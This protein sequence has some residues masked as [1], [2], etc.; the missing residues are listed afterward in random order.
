MCVRERDKKLGAIKICQHQTLAK[1]YNKTMWTW[2]AGSTKFI[3]FFQMGYSRPLFLYFHLYNSVDSKMFNINFCRW[4]DSDR[5]PLE[6]EATTLPTEPQPL[7]TKFILYVH[8]G[9][10]GCGRAVASETSGQSYKH[11]TLVNYDT[12]VVI[13]GIF[14]S[15]MTLVS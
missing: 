2:H 13:W 6:L 5:R 15:G 14:Q 7:T 9:S 4:V 11:F 8:I 3:L 12:R 1:M 10:G